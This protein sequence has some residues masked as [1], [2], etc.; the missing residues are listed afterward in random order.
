MKTHTL[1]ATL[2]VSLGSANAATTFLDVSFNGLPDGSLTTGT[3]ISNTGTGPDGLWDGGTSTVSSG[4]VDTIAND[5]YVNFS[6]GIG[7]VMNLSTESYTFTAVVDPDGSSTRG[8]FG[9]INTLTSDDSEFW[10][11]LTTTNDVQFLF[12][13]ASGHQIVA[14][15]ETTDLLNA[16]G[17]HTISLVVDGA[18]VTTFIDGSQIA[19]TSS[20]ILTDTIGTAND[21]FTVGA[22]NTTASNRFDGIADNYQITSIPEPSGFTLL[23]LAGSIMILRRRR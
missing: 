7:L 10:I 8:L 3:T 6:A 19:Q 16:A 15:H 5:G 17:F 4:T 18:N 11:R 21:R 1:L 22:Y 9:Q 23:G 13:D 2:I 12:R 20:V 14:T